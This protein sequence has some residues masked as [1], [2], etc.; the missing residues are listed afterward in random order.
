MHL[1]LKEIKK[2]VYN[3][4]PQL[5]LA[6]FLLIGILVYKDYGLGW[7]EF[8]QMTERGEV[9]YNFITTLD[10][11]TLLNSPGIYQ[12]PAFDLF[13]VSFQHCLNITD[14][15][16]IY[17]FRHLVTFVFF[18]L[19]GL[20]F[21]FLLRKKYTDPFIILIG[22]CW[23]FLMP[24]IFADSFCNSKDVPFLSM[25]VISLLSM[26]QFLEKPSWKTGI[27]HGLFCGFMIDI[28]LMGVLLP[29][30]TV[31]M[32]A[33]RVLMADE[34]TKTVL[35]YVIPVGLFVL[36]T[37]AF[38]V[39]FWPVLWLDPLHHF[40]KGWKVMSGFNFATTTLFREQYIY[41]DKLPWYYDAL[42]MG[43]T[44]P[45]QYVFFFIAG[46]CVILFNIVSFKKNRISIF[47]LEISSFLVFFVPLLV[48]NLLHSSEYDGWRHLFYLYAP[49]CI[50]AIRG[51]HEIQD[52]LVKYVRIVWINL[53]I[54]AITVPVAYT[55]VKMHP[56]QNIY[57]N[58]MIGPDAQSAKFKYEM[59]YW[60]VASREAL[61]KLY[62]RSTDTKILIY[63][64]DPP[65]PLSV[66]ILPENMRSKFIFT[67]YEKANYFITDYRWNP[68]EQDQ[69]NRID[70]I[71]VD[72]AVISSTYRLREEIK[73]V[74]GLKTMNGKYLYVDKS[75]ARPVLAQDNKAHEMEAFSIVYQPGNKCAI[76]TSEDKYFTAELAHENE[77]TASRDNIA[78]W[79]T[80]TI[81][82]LDSNRVA[83]KAANGKYLSVDEKM[84]RIYA[85]GETIGRQ[86]KFEI[87]IK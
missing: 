61:E 69:L 1:R 2:T 74:G 36:S 6:L 13:L 50:I 8:A 49:F 44:I 60:G 19:S 29:A 59:D 86:E 16:E 17:F 52:R 77:I 22:I 25:A 28:R 68:Q 83:F 20:A 41:T 87:I 45:L 10:S 4:L 14:S 84:P 75:S 23:Y 80:F 39:L 85:R 34:K 38:T 57:F 43:I 79:E 73:K 47:E 56:Y 18:W 51:L 71:K 7:D 42:W 26:M 55:M 76:Y 81:L 46:L 70:S 72:G 31:F 54:L 3:L 78:D 58:R 24:R 30:V 9:N 40:I 21:Y 15:R 11:K 64:M 37:V 82:E 32:F 5:G 66:A 53:L 12:G 67:T 35:S 62:L 63:A 33:L 27:L 65:A 48:I